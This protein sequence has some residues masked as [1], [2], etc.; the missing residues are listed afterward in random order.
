MKLNNKHT[1]VPLTYLS[2]NIK[3]LLTQKLKNIF[4]L[5]PIDRY[6]W[7]VNT[8]QLTSEAQ[9]EVQCALWFTGFALLREHN[10]F[11]LWTVPEPWLL[12][13][14]LADKCQKFTVTE[15]GKKGATPIVKKGVNS[16]K[17]GLYAHLCE[18]RGG[19]CVF[20][21]LV[22]IWIWSTPSPSY[23]NSKEQSASFL[24]LLVLSTEKWSAIL[25]WAEIWFVCSSFP[26]SNW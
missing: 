25:L 5:Q 4:I 12:H 24:I 16:V 8:M 17:Q 18:E 7:N 10:N 22:T 11:Y 1:E 23:C 2:V 6:I 21:L 3:Y 26:L 14:P 15:S 20:L 9:V 19:A 13:Q